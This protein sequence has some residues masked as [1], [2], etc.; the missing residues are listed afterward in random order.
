MNPK[1]MFCKD[2]LSVLRRCGQR[3]SDRVVVMVEANKHLLNGALC[4]KLMMDDLKMHKVVHGQVS[5][6]GPNTWLHG[7]EPIDR[8]WDLS[9]LE[10]IGA[11][12]LPYYNNLVDHW[13]VVVDL[14]MSSVLGKHIQKIA[15]AHARKLN[16]RVKRIREAYI[17]QLEK[18][19]KEHGI[20]EKLPARSGK[21]DYP[22]TKERRECPGGV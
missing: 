2:L 9:D 10:V 8:I 3:N 17:T 4:K 20:Y 19:F 1:A 18:T 21:T 6:P 5:G 16:S 11:S 14:S 7:K 15:P 13:L 12:Y 22:A